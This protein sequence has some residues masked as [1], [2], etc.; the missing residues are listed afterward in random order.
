MGDYL[1]GID[2]GTGG[3]KACIIDVEGVVLGSAFEEYPFYH[4]QPGWSEHDAYR[5]WT[6][7]CRMIRQCLDQARIDPRQ[8]RGIAVSSA[9]PSMV[10]VD[11]AG[12]PIER[13]YNL[14]DRRATAE[15][16]WLKQEIGEAR[17]Q[18]LTAN[19]IED[20]PSLVNL[21]W[22]RRNRPESFARIDKALTIDGFITRKLTGQNVVCH[23]GAAFYGVAYDLLNE[24]FDE[25]ML[26]DIGISPA[27][28][29]E[30]RRSEEILSL[31]HI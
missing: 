6:V 21:L 22:E 25:E 23:G 18:A 10:M 27:L 5:Y 8:I 26:T 2:Y 24:C 3:A 7:A 12:N 9:L 17:I 28:L 19:R 20:H 4:E 29:P 30:V 31:I 14:L 15:V 13:A 1:L 11:A 16:Q